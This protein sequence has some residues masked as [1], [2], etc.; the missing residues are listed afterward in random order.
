MAVLL[1]KRNNMATP[2]TL[3]SLATNDITRAGATG[4]TYVGIDF[5]TSTTVASVAIISPDGQFDIRPLDIEVKDEIGRRSTSQTTPT[6]IACVDGQPIFGGAAEKFK[7]TLTKDRDIWYS[8]KMELGEDLGNKYSESVLGEEAQFHVRNPKEATKFFFF[9]LKHQIESA[10]NKLGF[11]PDI[12]Y[13]VTIPASFEANQRKDLVDALKENGISVKDQ[14]LIDEPNA[15]FLSYVVDSAR[16]GNQICVPADENLNVLVFDYGAG[17]CDISILEIGK[18]YKGI[19]SKNRAISKFDKC[20][21]DDIDR[22]L[23][24]K[25]LLPMILRKNGKSEENLRTKDKNRIVARL[26]KPAEL[27]KI[28]ICNNVALKTTSEG[29]PPLS[30][31]DEVV[32]IQQTIN[33]ETRI[34]RLVLEN[35]GISYSQFNEAMKTFL[36]RESKHLSMRGE[37]EYNS[38][39]TNIQSALSKAS[40]RPKDIDYVLLIGGSSYNPYLQFGLRCYFSDSDLLIPSNLQ[41]HVSQGAAMHSLLFNAMNINVI[42]PITSEKILVVLR[43]GETKVLVP[44]SSVIPF[45]AHISAGLVVPNQGQKTVEVPICVGSKKQIL[46]V[47]KITCPRPEGY[48]KNESVSIDITITPDKLL[49]AGVWIDG[50]RYDIVPVNPFANRELTEAE[51]AVIRAQR[52]VNDDASRNNGQASKKSMKDLAD[53]YGRAKDYY[54]Q[55]ETYEEINEHYPG[56]ISNNEIHVAYH[57]SGHEDKSFKFIEEAYKEDPQN[58]TICFN[59]GLMFHY[60]DK[61]KYLGLLK[62]AYELDPTDITH[63]AAYGMELCEQGKESEGIPLVNKA[64]SKWKVKLQNNS[65]R[66]WEYGWFRSAARTADE[67]DLIPQIDKAEQGS[68]NPYENENLLKIYSEE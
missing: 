47:L 60:K 14:V 56:T 25:Y 3:A 50:E 29:L 36:S 12:E 67:L 40:M 10:V 38:V 28:K 31:S 62:R 64:I 22:F 20:G 19:Y 17:T 39:F 23:A 41:T 8:F 43:D 61:E 55:A 35:P 7:Y 58:A 5:G 65:F 13:A 48:H 46:S 45:D 27:I 66:S 34:G 1:Q 63:M 6:V 54:K 2:L 49:K 15:A 57:N 21:G 24:E 68:A 59:Y 16:S 26:L 18:D 37:D 11:S 9:W 52:A 51:S 42:N 53:A 32:S 33:F 4:K 44:Q 30:F